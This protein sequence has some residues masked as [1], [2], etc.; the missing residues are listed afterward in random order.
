MV[1]R[2]DSVH[3]TKMS[4]RHV[5]SNTIYLYSRYLHV[6]EIRLRIFQ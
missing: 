4:Y 2:E 5:V 3:P 6:V 1:Q